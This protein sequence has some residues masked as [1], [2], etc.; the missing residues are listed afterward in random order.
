MAADPDMLV[1]LML[2]SSWD[3]VQAGGTAAWRRTQDY[4]F[5]DEESVDTVFNRLVATGGIRVRSADIP[6]TENRNVTVIGVGLAQEGEFKGFLGQAAQPR[7][8][9]QGPSGET[10]TGVQYNYIRESVVVVYVVAPTKDMVRMVTRFVK[11]AVASHT[12]WF[13]KQGEDTA[14][15]FKGAADLAPVAQTVGQETVLRFVRRI[16]YAV[17]GVERLTPIDITPLTAK[18]ALVHA[19]GEVVANMPDH[20]TRTFTPLTPISLGKVRGTTDSDT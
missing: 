1:E 12:P 13:L 6:L 14:L 18:F 9:V 3:R 8:A 15:S 16:H 5:Y 19:D 20:E 7:R 4:A 17:K 11:T 2:R 10:M